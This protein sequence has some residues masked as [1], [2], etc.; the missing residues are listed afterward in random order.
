MKV[1]YYIVIL[2]VFLKPYMGDFISDINNK[3][4]KYEFGHW[5]IYEMNV[6]SFTSEGT[7]NAASAKLQ[8]LKDLG[9]DII[10]L[11]PIYVRDGGQSTNGIN[12][13]YAAKDFKNVN[14]SYG[15]KNDLKNFVNKAHEFNIQIWFDWVGA[16]TANNNQWLTDHPEYY[17]GGFHPVYKDVSP[18]NYANPDVPV[19]MTGILK[20]WID[21]AN[22]DGFR[23]DYI[24][25]P[26]VP[27]EYWTE[28]LIELKNYKPGITLLGEADFNDQ[29]RFFYKSWDYDYAWKFQETWLYKGVGSSDDV[30]K[31]R[32]YCESL[33]NDGR[34]SNLDRMTY[35]TNHDV[36]FNDNGKKLSVCMAIINMLLL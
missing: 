3:T 13:P 22:I 5:V 10:W 24:S 19:V 8:D 30:S 11:M 17:V 29:Q 21:T 20:Y 35:L 26:Y 1:A 12:S 32:E 15:T 25:S 9:I 7:F 33:V 31:L 6:G 4:K 34:Y 36:N 2:L 16:H 23:F 18:L 27:T 28:M 14:P